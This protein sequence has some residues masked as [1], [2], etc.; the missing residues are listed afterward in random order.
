MRIPYYSG[1]LVRKDPVLY[2]RLCGH[3]A[4]YSRFIALLSGIMRS[5][6]PFYSYQNVNYADYAAEQG[7]KKRLYS[8]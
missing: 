6:S 8:H 1:E 4:E 3:G 7:N 5:D 2:R